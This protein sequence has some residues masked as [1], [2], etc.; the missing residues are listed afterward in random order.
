MSTVDNKENWYRNIVLFLSSQTISLF[1]SSLVQ[2]AIMWHITL[3]TESGL[4]M[5][6]YILC[7]F[8][9]TFLLSPVAGVWADRYNRKLLIMISDGLIAFATLILALLF[10]MG[11]DSIWLLFVMAAVRA[12]GTGVQTPSVGA[13]LPQIVPKDKLTKVNGTNG[14]IQAVIMFVSPMVSAALLTMA[15][16]EAIFFIDVITAA[17]A[18]FTLLV[19]LKIPAHHKASLEQSTS[20][21]SDFKEGLKYVH[22]HAFLKK[23]F[24]YFSIF[25]VLMAPAA[26]LTPLQVTRSFGDDVWRLTAIEVAFSIGMMVGG[27][28][29]ATWGGLENK[30]KTMTLASIIM[31]VCTFALGTIPFFWI[32]LVFMALFGV[33][34]PIFNTPTTVL[35][36]EKIEEG[37]LGRVFGVLGMIS[38]S[39]MPIGM[40]IFGPL[41]DLI[42]VEWLLLGTGAFIIILSIF[43]GKDKALIEAGKPAI[44]E[45]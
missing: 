2:Y 6:L 22:N 31:G 36:Q 42:K 26:F 5:T 23:F 16:I 15:S 45:S 1:G 24:F 8:L 29:I 21:F 13:I 40:L 32:Y 14:S 20:Y 30:V 4:M 25:F 3:T 27:G 11:Y 34:M 39:M 37:F 38:T 9:P 41:A 19:F 43:L 7:G 17:I 18:I 28:L 33:A 10:L 44:Q 35:L 12:F